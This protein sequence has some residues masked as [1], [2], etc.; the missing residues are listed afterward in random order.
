M[1]GYPTIPWEVQDGKGTLTVA[2]IRYAPWIAMGK[3]NWAQLEGDVLWKERFR[4][5]GKAMLQC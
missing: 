1:T 5:Y 4:N 2:Q 3:K